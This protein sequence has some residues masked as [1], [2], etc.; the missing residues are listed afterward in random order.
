VWR[1]WE[2]LL[3]RRSGLPVP[4]GSWLTTDNAASAQTQIA[5]TFKAMVPPC[6]APLQAWN[7][8]MLPGFFLEH[9][10]ARPTNS[11]PA[12]KQTYVDYHCLLA[13]CIL[14]AARSFTIS[15]QAGCW[16]DSDNQTRGQSQFQIDVPLAHSP[17]PWSPLL[18]SSFGIVYKV[19]A[20]GRTQ[21]PIASHNVN[22]PV[23]AGYSVQC[24]A[25]QSLNVVGIL[26][27]EQ[28][29]PRSMFI[30]YIARYFP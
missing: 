3:L 12:N 26:R 17:G 23:K 29:S 10:T 1:V 6:D 22:L 19:Q 8:V 2:V 27:R 13:E 18:A 5:I 28:G 15:S 20:H 9:G 7:T 21:L 11:K 16:T 4:V 30:Q 25:V 24:S 14:L